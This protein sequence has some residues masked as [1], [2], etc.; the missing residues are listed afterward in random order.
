MDPV[1]GPDTA[2][3]ASLRSRRVGSRSDVASV[4]RSPPSARPPAVAISFLRHGRRAVRCMPSPAPRPSRPRRSGCSSSPPTGESM[5]AALRMTLRHRRP[6]P[7]RR[8]SARRR[9]GER[10][11]RCRPGRSRPP[12]RWIGTPVSTRAGPFDVVLPSPSVYGW[13]VGKSLTSSIRC[14]AGS[15]PPRGPTQAPLVEDSIVGGR[16]PASPQLPR[17]PLDD[18]TSTPASASSPASINPVAAPRANTPTRALPARPKCGGQGPCANPCYTLEVRSGPARLTPATSGLEQFQGRRPGERHGQ[19]E[20]LPAAGP[21]RPLHRRTDRDPV[22]D[23]AA[24]RV[25]AR[26]DPPTP[27]LTDPRLHSTWQGRIEQILFAVPRRGRST[28]RSQSRPTARS[29]RRCARARSSSSSLATAGRRR[30]VVPRR[31]PRRHRHLR[32]AAGL[33]QLH[34]LGGGRLRRAGRRHRRHPLPDG[35]V[36]VP[37]AGDALIADAVEESPAS[38]RPRR[39]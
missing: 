2:M 32:P 27:G 25:A 39:R 18:T 24:L 21:R 22:S 7:V 15:A 34:R 14:G 28:T 38:R 36:G 4:T 1:I 37:A 20:P 23:V 13:R 12:P 26:G 5:P 35:A 19:R 11:R 33:R 16:P 10:R 6:R 3:S 17:R 8:R 30:G 29:S 9:Q 31:R